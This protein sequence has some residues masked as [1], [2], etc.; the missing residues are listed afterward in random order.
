M[1]SN[2]QAEAAATNKD[3]IEQLETEKNQLETE[4]NQLETEK[5]QLE[6]E[7]NQ[8]E[9]EK[10]QLKSQK[11]EFEDQL[12]LYNGAVSIT[13]WK[14]W[15]GVLVVFVAGSTMGT[16]RWVAVLGGR[17]AIKILIF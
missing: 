11:E 14:F 15:V 4:K 10:N 2:K 7:K 17:K 1:R 12:E 5:N 9:T 13:C 8:L 6:T 3:R 16:M